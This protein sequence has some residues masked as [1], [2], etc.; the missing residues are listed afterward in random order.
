MKF[1]AIDF[2]TAN[3][4]RDSACAVAFVIVEDHKIIHK[5]E[6]L[7]R[8]PTKWFKFTD[9]HG[10]T[11]EDVKHEMTFE[12]QWDIYEKYL[13]GIE[14][15]A[16]HNAPFDRSV[17]QTCCKSYNIKVPE[18]EFRCTMQLSRDRWGIHPTTLADVCKEFKIPLKHHNAMS[19][20]LACAKIMIKAMKEKR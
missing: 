4:N 20:A 14:F 9:V 13:D 19:D 16:A 11:W 12:E 15:A 5:A 8:P 6:H 1:L 7:I 3:T 17:L 10:I 18:I 2:E